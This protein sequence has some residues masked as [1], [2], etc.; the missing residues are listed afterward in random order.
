MPPSP[1]YRL[2]GV[3]RKLAQANHHVS[4]IR[5]CIERQVIPSQLFWKGCPR[6]DFSDAYL[7]SK[8]ETILFEHAIDLRQ[9]AFDSALHHKSVIEQL[10]EDTTNELI[11]TH[12]LN[13]YLSARQDVDRVVGGFIRNLRDIENDKL[14]RTLSIGQYFPEQTTASSS[15]STPQQILSDG[16]L[17]QA[18]STSLIRSGQ[19]QQLL[20]TPLVCFTDPQVPNVDSRS[21]TPKSE[22]T[23][24]FSS[25]ESPLPD[26][27]VSTVA[28][29]VTNIYS[30]TTPSAI[31]PPLSGSNGERSS[32][33]DFPEVSSPI[34]V[35][36]AFQDFTSI[37]GR[38][39]SIEQDSS[40]PPLPHS[41]ANI[42]NNLSV[43]PIVPHPSI[44]DTFPAVF[45]TDRPVTETFNF[46]FDNAY[47]E[48]EVVDVHTLQGADVTTGYLKETMSPVVL[49]KDRF[50]SVV[51]LSSEKFSDA[52][53]SLLSKG[54][55][56]CPTPPFL[57]IQEIKCDLRKFERRIRLAEFFATN[58]HTVSSCISTPDSDSS[59]EQSVVEKRDHSIFR[60]HSSFTPKSDRNETLNTYISTVTNEIIERCSQVTHEV[61][62]ANLSKA[63]RIAIRNIEQKRNVVVKD[64]DKG[65]AIVVMDRHRYVNEAL[66]H[67]SDDHC[68]SRLYSDPTQEY[69]SELKV[70]VGRLRGE[71]VLSADQAKFAIPSV[72][73]TARFYILPKIH[74]SGVPGRPV[75]SCSSSLTENISIIVDW[76]VK[77]LLPTIPSYIKD[78]NEFLHR[79]R[80][81]G[82]LPA[83]ALLVTL[84]VV[85]LYPS[86]PHDGGLE[87]LSCFLRENLFSDV[88]TRG[89]LDLARFVLT[90]NY[91]EVDGQLYI[92]KSGTAT[93]TVWL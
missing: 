63:E 62:R 74:K 24:A 20:E 82:Q 27:Y 36:D 79:L 18:A 61:F 41:V 35:N 70:L 6:F 68:Y 14:R 88:V 3:H 57:N 33:G 91:F 49:G 84:D 15:F 73:R 1:F 92:Q 32:S 22:R 66:R 85:A 30:P 39:D 83:N 53:L 29:P 93:G 5:K 45:A 78:T 72:C 48:T 76:F 2:L 75:C 43:S 11:D 8:W 55:S 80:G 40:S 81:L 60:S 42:G 7:K 38:R 13:F 47:P 89:I 12:G 69:V 64:A 71:N 59:I 19:F 52:E 50:A 31:Q 46:P 16:C 26:V 10:V 25:E 9:L 86:I 34:L 56:F 87:A 67:L 4:F 58:D 23:N 44:E 21:T 28:L 65:S 90:R 37:D 51:N 17:S 77:P 54:L